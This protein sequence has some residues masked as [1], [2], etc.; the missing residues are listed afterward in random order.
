MISAMTELLSAWAGCLIVMAAAILITLVAMVWII[1]FRKNARR[2]HRRR[3]QHGEH[4]QPN[5]TLAQIDGLPP[6]RRDEKSS[7]SQPPTL[8]AQS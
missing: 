4:H 7:R 1:F 8:T 5:P 2:R 6:A 3:R